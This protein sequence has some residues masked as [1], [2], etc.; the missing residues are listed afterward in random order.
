MLSGAVR[1]AARSVR[2]NPAFTF[3]AVLTLA[4]GIGANTAVFTL[5]DQLLLRPLPVKEPDTLVLVSA[6]PLP[7]FGFRFGEGGGG[8][9][10]DGKPTYQSS[11][12]LFTALSERVPAFAECFAQCTRPASVLV[13]DA[14]NDL[15][16]QLVSGNYFAV[17]GIKAAAGRLL[18]P[19]DDR[20]GGSPV[21]VISHGYWQ[22]QFAGDPAAVGRTIRLSG[23][24]VT[25]VGVAAA[26]FTGLGGREGHPPDFFV[27]LE[28]YDTLKRP[29]NLPLRSP[30]A[31][32]LE[33]FARLQPGTSIEQ[34]QVAGERVY[35]QLLAEAVG[36]RWKEVEESDRRVSRIVSEHFESRGEP[37]KAREARERRAAGRH[38][39]VFPAGYG[40]S[41]QSFVNPQ[42]NRALQVLMVMAALLLLIGASNVANLI[43]ARGAAA[44]REVA[45]CLVLGASRARLLAERLVDNLLVAAAAGL[46]SLLVSQWLADVLLMILPVG[47]GQSPLTTT[48]DRRTVLFAFA[49]ALA[50]GL[51][52]WLTSSLQMTRRSTLP[53]VT[54]TGLGGVSTRP[55]RLRRGLLALQTAL[56]LAL[57][58]AASMFA[59]SLLNLT[60]IDAGFSVSGLTTFAL[61]PSGADASK[62]M[63]PLVRDAVAAFAGI[64]DVQSVAGT[65]SLPLM[66]SG[67]TFV[68]GGN[69][70]LNAEKAVMAGEVSVTPGYFRTIGLPVVR[71]REFDEQDTGGTERVAV[72]NE[73]LARALFGDRNAIGEKVGLQH[74]ALD[75][76]VVGV[77]RDTK[78]SLRRP[79]EPA[80][81][82]PL[83]QQ[84]VPSMT[85]VVRTRSG[86]P[87]DAATVRA[88][89]NRIDTTTPV[90]DVN[91]MERL[92]DGM[93]SRDRILA[94]LS[95][96][97]AGL[98]ALLCGLGLF[99]M[100]NFH[101][102]TRQRELG[103]RLALGAERRSI[104]WIVVREAAF[105]ILA[106]A[107][108]GLAAYFASSHVVGSFLFELSPTDAPTVAAAACMLVVV[109]L[110]AAFVPA[111]RATLLDPAVILRRE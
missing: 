80:M 36:D 20:E 18:S 103:I 109:A 71:G 79:P 31:S 66:N 99:G 94:Q 49:V 8:R 59:H 61:R 60:S 88:V 111:R 41:S 1:H 9:R 73:S 28:L 52:V 84:P 110:A 65:N 81:Y 95:S 89:V 70:P 102:A 3:V 27:P 42:L 10:P 53:P 44:R 91:T 40:L 32:M 47:S 24:P 101:A 106:G 82:V 83:A 100:M 62:Q 57:L 63:G 25:I 6:N 92:I 77:V 33:V 34:A 75:R 72:V 76:T 29:A 11:H 7:K 13:G 78:E 19:D 15:W 37:D 46:V 21:A 86:R 30:T 12:E 87:L 97:F 74:V 26:G 67:G 16:G 107:P 5:I 17:L 108:V 104:Q 55:L 54:D 68:A 50:S 45:I 39:T 23:H 22:R 35:Q 93:L 90:S 43:V 105:V 64:A 48:P 56:S 51:F 85:V 96:A 98:A 4:L 69:V 14:P 2:R 58:C 38:L